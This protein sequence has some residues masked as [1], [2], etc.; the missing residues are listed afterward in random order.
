MFLKKC[1]SEEMQVLHYYYIFVFLFEFHFISF[2][3]LNHEN[4]QFLLVYKFPSFW[5]NR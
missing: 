4:F 2:H 1:L 3:S 5:L